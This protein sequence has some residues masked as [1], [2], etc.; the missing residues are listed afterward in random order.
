MNIKNFLKRLLEPLNNE[1]GWWYAVSAAISALGSY[2]S[3]SKASKQKTQTQQEYGWQQTQLYDYLKDIMKKYG[4]GYGA[5]TKY[6]GKLAIGW[7]PE[8]QQWAEYVKGYARTTPAHQEALKRALSGEAVSFEQTKPYWDYLWKEEVEP[9]TKAAYAGPGYWGSARAEAIAKAARAQAA[10]Q[11]KM[12]YQAEEAAQERALKAIPYSLQEEARKQAVANLL[13][14]VGTKSRE[15]EQEQL[16]E[17]L[18]RWMWGEEVEG[19]RAFWYSPYYQW[20]MQMLETPAK[21]Q[22][23]PS[24]LRSTI[25]SEINELISKYGG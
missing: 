20:I 15:I 23:Y 4:G 7:T 19:Q 6:P 3:A 10:E 8:E 18:Q 12:K 9:R 1:N 24:S 11:A 14:E 25:E 13:G 5:P 22:E 17:T 2:L 16:A 21:F